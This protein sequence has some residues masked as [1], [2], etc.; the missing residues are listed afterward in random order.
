MIENCCKSENDTLISK[1][2]KD[3]ILVYFL[4]FKL[5]CMLGECDEALE[6]FEQMQQ[7][8]LEQNM[9]LEVFNVIANCCSKNQKMSLLAMNIS[10]YIL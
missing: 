10:T 7:C 9:L 2:D 8:E 4:A 5:H 1:G 3:E 6:M